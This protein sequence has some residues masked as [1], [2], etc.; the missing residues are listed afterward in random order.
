MAFPYAKDP[1][2]GSA[3]IEEM[4]AVDAAATPDPLGRIAA[5]LQ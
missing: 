4:L 3:P 5:S 1:I 2:D